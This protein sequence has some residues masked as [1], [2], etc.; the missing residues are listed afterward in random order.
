[1]T[2]KASGGEGLNMSGMLHWF[3]AQRAWA[4]MKRCSALLSQR[5]TRLMN[6][7]AG[8]RDIRMAMGTGT[9]TDVGRWFG[10]GRVCLCLTDM[11]LLLFAVG[12]RSYVERIPVHGLSESRYNHVTGELV[13]APAEG[14]RVTRLKM[15]P[16]DSLGLLEL[17]T[18]GTV[19]GPQSEA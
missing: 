2:T 16:L 18:G 3:S 6:E 4:R 19:P 9:R 8:T 17:V 12:K 14:A 11:E 7:L 1:M 10:K 5:K 13:L 15:P